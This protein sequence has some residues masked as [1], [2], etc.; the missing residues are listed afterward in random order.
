MKYRVITLLLLVAFIAAW[1]ATFNVPARTEHD[2]TE[3]G[4]TLRRTLWGILLII[5]AVAVVHCRGQRQAFFIGVLAF[6]A[7]QVLKL[8][9]VWLP[10]LRR[11]AYPLSRMGD[12]AF[13]LVDWQGYSDEEA[14]SL[15]RS[16]HSTFELLFTLIV[17][18]ICGFIS[19]VI[20]NS[21]RKQRDADS[22]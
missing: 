12:V 8:P 7:V 15:Q 10:E 18:C 13:K 14:W 21:S 16:V 4:E 20:Y 6:L 9:E 22:A 5:P 2:S 11:E 1:L 17:C 19:V 3:L